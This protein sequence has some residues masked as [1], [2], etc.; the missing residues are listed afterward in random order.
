MMTESQEKV[1]LIKNIS[2]HSTRCTYNILQNIQV[3]D[4]E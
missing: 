1:S 4:A 2:D 3:P